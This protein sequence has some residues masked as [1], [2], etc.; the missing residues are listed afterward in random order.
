MLR[1]LSSVAAA[2]PAWLEA[3]HGNAELK[4]LQPD[5]RS[6][7]GCGDEHITYSL[8]DN[9]LLV[10]DIFLNQSDKVVEAAFHVSTGLQG[11]VGI[12]HGGVAAVCIDEM[13]GCLSALAGVWPGFTRDL[14][15]TFH[16]PLRVPSVVY[17]RASITNQ[18]GRVLFLAGELWDLP[19]DSGGSMLA[20][21]HARF[22]QVRK[23]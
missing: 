20:D 22:M 12:A 5:V 3:L 10:S 7:F 14:K 15:V 11:H 19:P 1:R 8:A 6:T 13:L 16:A 18:K 23:E 17:G 4:Y 9:G 21:G 2:R